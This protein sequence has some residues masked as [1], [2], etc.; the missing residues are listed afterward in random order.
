MLNLDFSTVGPSLGY[1][2]GEGMLTSLAIT[3]VA[4]IF[5]M[6]LGGV[7]A[8]MR[9]SRHR[10]LSWPAAFYINSFRSL[11]LILIIFGFYFLMPY[12]G[13]WILRSPYPVNIGAFRAALISFTLFEAAYFAEIIRSGIQ[14]IP[15]GQV[16]AGQAI[17][18]RPLTILI[19]IVLPQAVRNMIPPLLLRTLILFQDTS[20]VYVVSLTD[21]LGA[22]TKLGQRD[23]RLTEMY[24][25]VAVTYFV[26]CFVVSKL[27]NRLD[28]RLKRTQ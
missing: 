21:F 3:I 22:A 13:A 6:L 2:F 4:G 24:L 1:L 19:H 18:L 5:G 27:V 26:I 8:V 10:W 23:G 14:S 12:V 28:Q 11:P 15:K 17:G 9:L 25:L 7:L 16:R 20:L